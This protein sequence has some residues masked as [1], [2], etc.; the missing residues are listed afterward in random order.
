MFEGTCHEDW[1]DHCGGRS[2]DECTFL[3]CYQIPFSVLF[4]LASSIMSLY[5]VSLQLNIF[6][7]P[8]L[9]H[10]CLVLIL[11]GWLSL[12][13]HCV[14]L[15][16]SASYPILSTGPRPVHTARCTLYIA[17]WTLYTVHCTLVIAHC[18][19]VY[20]TLHIAHYT[21]FFAHCALYT[22]HTAHCKMYIAQCTFHS[23][24]WMLDTA[25]CSAFS[26]REFRWEFWKFSAANHKQPDLQF[27]LS[28]WDKH[29]T[30]TV[31][32]QSLPLFVLLYQKFLN[33]AK[34]CRANNGK[35][36][37]NNY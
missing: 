3:V 35:S 34:K 16:C 7:L 11:N 31:H 6:H 23:V 22:A 9:N 1:Q 21:L 12:S 17:R 4:P 26:L 27:R 36:L 8:W 15:K 33:M 10:I 25:H 20:S 19:L 32:Q 14:K 2:K 30:D 37:A 29:C 5:F 18:M 13:Q 28:G 24:H